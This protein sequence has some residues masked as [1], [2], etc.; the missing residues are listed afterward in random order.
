MQGG[1]ESGNIAT[2]LRL[3]SSQPQ[4]RREEYAGLA[5]VFAE[6]ARR[7]GVWKQALKGWNMRQSRQVLEWQ[8]EARVE[9]LLEVLESRFG[10][11]PEDLTSA[12]RALT[13]TPRIKALAPLVGRSRS[14][15]EF[16]RDA[17]L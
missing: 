13:S 16:R 10:E 12:L 2:W 7:Q 1:D 17:K 6:A 11:L 5:L 14:L 3:M 4:A 15:E 9:T 8:A